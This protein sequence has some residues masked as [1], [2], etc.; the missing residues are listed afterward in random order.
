MRTIV[1]VSANLSASFA[2]PE[3]VSIDDE[4]RGDDADQRRDEERAPRGARARARRIRASSRRRLRAILAEHGTK[5]CENAPSANR[6][7]SRFGIRKATTKAS[8]AAP[9]PKRIASSVSRD[10]PGDARQERHAAHRS[11]GLEQVHRRAV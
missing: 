10:E 1:T 11:G 2:K 5:A 3:A 6:R 9:A 8:I 7:R 4:R